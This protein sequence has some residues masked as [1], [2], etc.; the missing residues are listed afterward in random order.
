[1]VHAADTQILFSNPRACEL[2]GLS[3]S[4]MQGK[5][6]V[7]PAWQFVDESG[8]ALTPADYPVNRVLATQQPLE[9]F[10]LG[11]QKPGN[12]ALVWLQVSAF[13]EF[14]DTGAL[15]QIIVNF[16]DV[17]GLKRAEAALRS[18]NALLAAAKEAAEQN[19]REVAKHSALLSILIHALPD[20]IWLKD[21]NGQY[22]ACN[23]RFEQFFGKREDEIVG[24]TDYD[25]VDRA[26]AEFFRANDRLAMEKGGP[27]INEEWITFASDG[28][29]ELLETTKTPVQSADGQLIGILGIGHDIT[30]GQIKDTTPHCP[31]H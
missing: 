11:V 8:T 21:G 26:L 6:A 3:E 1:V 10:V 22:L 13:P 23:Q 14:D 5:T 17:T 24:H 15:S 25:F 20:L 27:S 16:Y 4:Q 12:T 29:R 2:L 7:D 18:T 19:A 28:H 30:W 9:A 31:R